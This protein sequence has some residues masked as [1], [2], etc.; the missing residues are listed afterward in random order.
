[1][2]DALQQPGSPVCLAV[3]ASSHLSAATSW[4]DLS[5]CSNVLHTPLESA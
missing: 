5:A 3:V 1:L 4:A 2:E